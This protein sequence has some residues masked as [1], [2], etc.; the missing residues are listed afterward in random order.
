M[1]LTQKCVPRDAPV[2]EHLELDEASLSMIKF[3][4]SNR[5]STYPIRGIDSWN[6][7]WMISY[8]SLG[9][10]QLTSQRKIRNRSPVDYSK[11]FFY[12]PDLGILLGEAQTT[13]SVLVLLELYHFFGL[14]DTS[15][16]IPFF[17]KSPL[18]PSSWF[19]QAQQFF[20]VLGAQPAQKSRAVFFEYES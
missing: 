6:Y 13:T 3:Q 11:T 8:F 4:Y 2:V 7:I 16:Q 17:G 10:H 15:A 20:H 1:K 9:G 14:R 19:C 5:G 12:F 18:K